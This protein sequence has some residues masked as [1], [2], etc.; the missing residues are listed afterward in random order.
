MS[1]FAF[2]RKPFHLSNLLGY[3]AHFF[4]ALGLILALAS[5][6]F[7]DGPKSA[8]EW[9][10]RANENYQEG[11]VD[12]AIGSLQEALKLKKDYLE[13][14]TLL[15]AAYVESGEFAKAIEPYKA[16]T[17]LRPTD[18]SIL[19]GYS[20]ALEGA[21]KQEEELPVLKKLF[22]MNK[23]DMVT[24]IKYLTLMEAAG[25][26][27]HVVDYI[28]VLEDLRKLPN[29]DPTYTAKLARAYNK[30]GDYA[31]AVGVYQELIKTSPESGE[32]WTG[33]ANAQAKVDP[34]AAKASYKK[35]IL[36][37]DRADER[38]K[39]EKAMASLGSAPAPAPAAPAA[40]PVAAA[41]VAPAAPVAAPVA[42]VVPAAPVA[43]APSA[44]DKA[45][46]AAEAKAQAAADRKAA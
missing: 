45:K 15:G 13:A 43:A 40:A 4:A 32:Y 16:A 17:E 25:R 18:Y 38:A 8:E 10:K 11:N 34:A 35:A 9:F 41:P 23:N 6:G 27:K 21:G 12:E 2:N 5:S 3:G 24:G 33:L 31:K 37:T 7:A 20:N 14:L 22:N 29:F 28:A 36:Y 39:L 46:A 44:A 19:L 26:E 1:N 30:T 42:P